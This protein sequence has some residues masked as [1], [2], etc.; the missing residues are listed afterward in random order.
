MFYPLG[1]MLLFSM[2]WSA[3]WF[4]A[5]NRAQEE[6]ALQRKMLKAKGIGLVCRKESWG[7][8][9]FR[10]E[11]TC[12]SPSL[13]FN[14]MELKTARLRAVAQAYNP[15]HILLL[16][17]GP[18][19]FARSDAILASASHKGAII[20]ITYDTKGN[21]DI[22]SEASD[23][24]VPNV[25]TAAS[26]KFFARQQEGKIDLAG[27]ADGVIAL[28]RSKF[29]HAE[30]RGQVTSPSLQNPAVNISSLEITAGSVNFE[31]QGDIAVDNAHLI[32]GSISSQTNDID[33][34][35]ALL[36]PLLDLKGDDIVAVK[37]LLLMQG[38]DMKSPVQKAQFTARN[39]SIYLGLLKLADVEPLY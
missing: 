31:A 22:S 23:V 37:G 11:F 14:A 10:F 21:W 34:V 32:S 2:I 29:E 27:N 19:S 13:T 7:G 15:F 8:F 36:T 39:G 9:P 17:D 12:N 18:T 30:F 3:Y 26:V 25:I 20:S 6:V 35:L 4:V 5:S 1:F 24:M 33:G 28:A 16:V 38:N